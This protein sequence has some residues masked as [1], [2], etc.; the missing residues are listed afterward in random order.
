[1][2]NFPNQDFSGCECFVSMSGNQVIL[3]S[4]IRR[5]IS[6]DNHAFAY[7]QLS[8]IEYKWSLNTAQVYSLRRI[9]CHWCSSNIPISILGEIWLEINGM[10][11]LHLL[12]TLNICILFI[13]IFSIHG[14]HGIWCDPL[15]TW[16]SWYPFYP[17]IILWCHYLCYTLASLGPLLYF[18]SF[19]YFLGFSISIF[20]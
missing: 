7:N 5:S 2:R 15:Y 14:M 16:Y 18:L 13:G 19:L 6:R 20:S 11:L 9:F 1:M 12:H 17:W 4:M 3:S 10:L 8:F